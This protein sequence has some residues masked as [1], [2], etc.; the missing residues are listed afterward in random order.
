[1]ENI[2]AVCSVSQRTL[3]GL[4]KQG[5][6]VSCYRTD[7]CLCCQTQLMMYMVYSEIEIKRCN[8]ELQRHQNRGL[9]WV[10]TGLYTILSLL[11]CKTSQ[12][13]K[14]FVLLQNLRASFQPMGGKGS[15][16]AANKK[17]GNTMLFWLWT[18]SEAISALCLCC[19]A[20]LPMS[21]ALPLS[22]PACHKTS[23]TGTCC[24]SPIVPA[25]C[26]WPGH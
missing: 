3:S 6:A 22:Q 17:A 18:S 10:W 13:D 5:E 9:E 7:G 19:A 25:K 11:L 2:K 26:Q 23:C 4:N 8:I 12:P 14:P 1:M 24:T 20:V 16:L 15:P 21:P